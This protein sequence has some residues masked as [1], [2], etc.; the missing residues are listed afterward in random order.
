MTRA[1]LTLVATLLLT[2]CAL[3]LDLAD[4]SGLENVCSTADD[5]GSG[6]VCVSG[7]C[8]ATKVDLT[9]MLVE[10]KPRSNA[11][12][13]ANTSYLFDPAEAD[14]PLLSDNGQPFFARMD[15]TLPA[16]VAIRE[17]RVRVHPDTPLEQGCSIGADRAIPAS[18]K[19]YR[20]SP[21]AGLVFDSIVA[22]TGDG[23]LLDVDLVRGTYNVYV[24]PLEV[25]GCNG[26]RA[27]PPALRS[28]VE[29]TKD[30][31]TLLI[32]LPVVSTL[33]GVIHEAPEGIFEGWKI[34]FVEPTRGLPISSNA[35]LTPDGMGGHTVAAQLSWPETDAPILR[36]APSS[37]IIQP[38]AYWKL[39]FF[40][41]T[42]TTPFIEHSAKDLFAMPVTVS[43]NVLGTDGFTRIRASLSIRSTELQGTNKQNAAYAIENVETD[44]NGV[45]SLLVPPGQYDFR[46][47]PVDNGLAI[48]DKTL[49]RISPGT[50]C[51]CGLTFDLARKLTI[52]GAVKTPTGARLAGAKVSIEPAGLPPTDY[53]TS[54][55]TP[56]PI[57]AREVSAVSTSDGNFSL[58]ADAGIADLVIEAAE[59]SGFPRLVRPNLK[60][61]VDAQL[62]SLEITPPAILSGN[63]RDPNGA[64][65]ANAEINA[66]FPVRQM[67]RKGAYTSVSVKIATTSTDENGNYTLVLPSSI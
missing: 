25:P 1:S 37:D 4:P 51:F 11:V 47:L 31:T 42:T 46:A 18:V 14:I 66:W 40:Q 33:T 50:D 41:G 54:T 67:D 24:E 29:I 63:V 64:A 23:N 8:I 53:W 48:T 15:P 61:S 45:F 9:G 65:V 59:G 21:F 26:G 2:G 60:L 62:A 57:V 32:D 56:T 52:S 10:V 35:T 38:T 49:V 13:G 39:L 12:F 58:L 55:H 5:C 22:S 16:P 20:V 36:I 17:A 30:T 44:E 7:A 6:A 34:D 3:P 43:G 28:G 27:F 19:F